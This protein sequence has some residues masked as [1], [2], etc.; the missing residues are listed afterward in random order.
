MEDLLTPDSVGLYLVERG[1]IE[2]EE[3]VE[4]GELG[5]GIS[6]VVIAVQTGNQSF[7]VKQSLPRLRV[8]DDWPAKRE[9]S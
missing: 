8:K 4:S 6:N 1:L 3:K 5:G 7:V 9:R 2:A